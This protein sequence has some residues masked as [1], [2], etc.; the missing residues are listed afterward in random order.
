MMTVMGEAE[1]PQSIVGTHH[2]KTNM[3]NVVNTVEV[4]PTVAM[5]KTQVESSA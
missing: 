1:Y 4:S 2:N 5:G 3:K